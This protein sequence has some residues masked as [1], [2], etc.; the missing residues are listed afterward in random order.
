MV[1]WLMGKQSQRGSL[2]VSKLEQRKCK[3]FFYVAEHRWTTQL[4][5]LWHGVPMA[6][7]EAWQSPRGAGTGTASGVGGGDRPLL[8]AGAT[9]A[10]SSWDALGFC[11]PKDGKKWVVGEEK[12]MRRVL[13]RLLNSQPN[14]WNIFQKFW[15]TIRD[16]SP[17]EKGTCLSVLF[18]RC[19][20]LLVMVLA[21]GAN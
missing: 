8:P 20:Q 7:V 1:F 21:I 19:F 14:T 16:C 12:L 11:H 15:Q 6:L 4:L 10:T 3:T 13:I 9:P 18:S 17:E 5:I 2:K